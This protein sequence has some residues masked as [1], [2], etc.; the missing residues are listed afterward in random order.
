MSDPCRI[1]LRKTKGSK[2]SL[3][4]GDLLEKAV[5]EEF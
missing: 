4:P 5:F 3:L 1:V 2:Q